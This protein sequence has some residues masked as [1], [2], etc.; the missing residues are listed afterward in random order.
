MSIHLQP[1]LQIIEAAFIASV[2]A[3]VFAV[4]TWRRTLAHRALAVLLSS[5]VLLIVLGAPLRETAPAAVCALAIA[6]VE[7][8]QR[9]RGST[10]K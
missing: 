1:L 3:W 6:F 10:L 8:A 7:L 4:L 2:V 5:V 9:H